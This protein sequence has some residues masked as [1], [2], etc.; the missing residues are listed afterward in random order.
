MLGRQAIYQLSYSSSPE[1]CNT[2][3]M[4]ENNLSSISIKIL[5]K[6]KQNEVKTKESNDQEVAY[7]LL[8]GH[9]WLE[10]VPWEGYISSS[11]KQKQVVDS[12][13]KWASRNDSYTFW[14][15]WNS[16]AALDLSNNRDCWRYL[17]FGL[18]GMRN[19]WDF[20]FVF[21]KKKLKEF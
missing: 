12:L 14:T 9:G 3:N 20:Y 5:Q 19:F 16:Q 21:C 6:E 13:L 15:H 2:V 11:R 4:R 17:A 8:G 10:T 18:A 7:F 1:A